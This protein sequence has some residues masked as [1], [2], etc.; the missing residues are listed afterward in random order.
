[1]SPVDLAGRTGNNAL[2]A[3]SW[4]D[5]DPFRDFHCPELTPNPTPDGQYV[6]LG[7]EYVVSVNGAE[8]R[9]EPGASFGGTFIDYPT[10]PWRTANCPT[11]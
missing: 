6:Q 9:P 11:P 7:I 4:R 5:A 1:M 8:I 10:T 2:Y 3:W